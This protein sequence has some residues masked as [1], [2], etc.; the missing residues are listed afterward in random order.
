MTEKEKKENIENHILRYK[1]YILQRL[2]L[3]RNVI[4]VYSGWTE[5][6]EE[7][8]NLAKPLEILID[9]ETFLNRLKIDDSTKYLE[10]LRIDLEKVFSCQII[11]GAGGR[12]D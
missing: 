11:F 1:E 5:D 10:L 7:G 2:M 4:K 8:Y 12:N 9:F 6:E 3:E